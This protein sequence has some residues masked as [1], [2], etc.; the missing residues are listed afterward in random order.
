[1]PTSRDRHDDMFAEE[2]AKINALFEEDLELSLWTLTSN[3][4]YK[5]DA[6]NGR[7]PNHTITILYYNDQVYMPFE[8][9]DPSRSLLV[10]DH[11]VRVR[12][13]QVTNIAN[14]DLRVLEPNRA[15][16]GKRIHSK[17]LYVHPDLEPLRITDVLTWAY[18]LG[19]YG[20]RPELL[21]Y[22]DVTPE[23]ARSMADIAI[24]AVTIRTIADGIGP[25]VLVDKAAQARTNANRIMSA[26]SDAGWN[27]ALKRDQLPFSD[28]ELAEGVIIA[29]GSDLMGSLLA[30]YDSFCDD[31]RTTFEEW[32]ADIDLDQLSKHPDAAFAF[33]GTVSHVRMLVEYLPSEHLSYSLD[34]ERR[35]EGT[36]IQFKRTIDLS[37]RDASDSDSW[38]AAFKEVSTNFDL[39][40]G[41]LSQARDAE[42]LSILDITPGLLAF[43]DRTLADLPRVA[44]GALGNARVVLPPSK[45][46]ARAKL[47]ALKTISSDGGPGG[48]H[49]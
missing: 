47:V 43:K 18:Q 44:A 4:T 25:N 14:I 40:E 37:G 2:K 24:N 27:C 48:P 45:V 21:N 19:G 32:A 30:D 6:V 22:N 35:I 39:D 26:L 3:A 42:V 46:A 38:A 12:Y 28:S 17:A 34:I 33:D 23:Q 1:M 9:R 36:S 41:I 10:C 20:N 16:T 49:L 5:V 31:P 7:K 13:G 11:D 15:D 29:S 8:N